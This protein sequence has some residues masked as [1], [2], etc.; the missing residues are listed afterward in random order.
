MVPAEMC[1]QMW[2]MY[3]EKLPEDRQ[4]AL[5]MPT[6]AYRKYLGRTAL[7]LKAAGQDMLLSAIKEGAPGPTVETPAKKL[8]KNETIAAELRS[9][10]GDDWQTIEPEWTRLT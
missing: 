4:P 3:K 2:Q 10:Y 5:R 9:K 6:R 1:V 7:K 8:G